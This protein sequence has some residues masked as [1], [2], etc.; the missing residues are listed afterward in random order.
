[1]F[2]DV[3]KNNNKLSS[4]Q[5]STVQG[6]PTSVGRVVPLSCAPTT[7]RSQ[8]RATLC[9]TTRSKSN[10]TSVRAKWTARLLKPW[11][12]RTVRYSARSSLCLMAEIICTRGTLCLSEMIVWNW[13]WVGNKTNINHYHVASLRSNVAKF[14]TILLTKVI[15]HLQ[16]GFWILPVLSSAS[17]L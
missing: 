15:V 17:T 13:R 4:P 1:M 7:F 3:F 2:D 12:M 5:C 16:P 11:Y 8:C 6:D 9:I 14:D 10:L